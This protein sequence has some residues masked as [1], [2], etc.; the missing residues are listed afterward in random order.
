MPAPPKACPPFYGYEQI[1]RESWDVA[2]WNRWTFQH[3]REQMPTTRVWRGAGP[4]APLECALRDLGGIEF[5]CDVGRLTVRD[6]LGSSDTDGFLVLH[7]GRVVTELYFNCMARATPHSVQSVSKSIVGSVAGTLSARGV[8]CPAAAVTDYLPELGNTAYRGATVQQV[9][10]MSTGVRWDENYTSLDSNVARMDA[11]SGW[12]VRRDAS[13]PRSMWELLPTL[14][15]QECPH[16]SEFR[17]RSIETDVLAF[18]LQRATGRPLADLVSSELWAPLGAEEDGFFTVDPA[19]F[20]CAC[21]GFNATLRDLG[22]FA[23]L[24]AEGGTQAGREILPASWFADTR[25][26]APAVFAGEYLETLPTGG[27]RNQFWLERPGQGPVLARGAFGQLVYA[28]PEAG[29]AAVKLS[30]WPVFVD[31]VRTRTALAAIR[32]IRTELAGA[33]AAS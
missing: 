4:A 13:W 7:H 19:G 15:E 1:P 3:M 31:G 6:W 14:T 5:E 17:Y 16:G 24:L 30:C 33:L 8:L 18:V 23:R 10:D 9:L 12:K 26:G 20:A 29:F 25:R 27:Y 28:D 22:R 21:G 11:A 32:A 2:P